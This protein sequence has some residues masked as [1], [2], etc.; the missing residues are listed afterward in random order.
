[1]KTNNG[2]TM[3]SPS[4]IPAWL[5]AQ[6]VTRS[7]RLVQEHHTWQ[8]DY[9][10]FN[11]NN[12]FTRQVVMRESHLQRG[13]ADI[14][15]HFTVF[16]DGM[17]VTG[18]MLADD[19]A[20]IVGANTGAVCIECFGNFDAG[21]D[22]MTDAQAD[23]IV[24][25][26]AALC[27]RFALNPAKA[28]TYHAWW[29]SNGTALG[30]YS[31]S[32]SAKTCPGTAFFGGNSKAAFSKYFLPRV[33]AA[34]QGGDEI[35]SYELFCEYMERYRKEHTYKYVKDMPVWAQEAATLAI[36][37]GTLAMDESGAVSLPDV[38]AQ[39]LE[40]MRRKR[41]FEK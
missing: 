1:M 27:N 4:E 39:P 25:L 36:Q 13:F 28:I 15:Q 34:M 32:H 23:A 19:P 11:G 24:Q 18:R 7:I 6:T 12:H 17:T 29:T 31:P 35:V 9:S 8:P 30:D 3:L 14:A 41:M 20:G 37:D 10:H 2:F 21:Q 38:N 40:W 16:P 5:D 22:S 33:I 26:T